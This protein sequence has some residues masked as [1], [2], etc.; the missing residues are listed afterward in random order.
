MCLML[1]FVQYMIFLIMKENASKKQKKKQ[2]ILQANPTL[3]L[4][5]RNKELPRNY[6]SSTGILGFHPA[7]REIQDG[8][9][10]VNR[11]VNFKYDLRAYRGFLLK[12]SLTY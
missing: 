6:K 1:D 10:R 4:N 8:D 2:K 3:W 7:S 9:E 5:L 11:L 12:D